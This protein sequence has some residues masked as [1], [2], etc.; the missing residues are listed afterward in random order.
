MV[1]IDVLHC[2]MVETLTVRL[3]EELA[4]ELRRE[5]R[6]SGV[7]RGEIVRQ[8]IAARIRQT[9]SRTVMQRHFGTMRGPADLSTNKA[10]RRAWTKRR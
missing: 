2:G 6:E 5:A 3:G 1:G 8:A 10:Y 4:E 9:A 7:S